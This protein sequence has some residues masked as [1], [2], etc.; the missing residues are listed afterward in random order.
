MIAL[1]ISF[2]RMFELSVAAALVGGIVLLFR[3]LAKRWVSPGCMVVLWLIVLVKLVTPLTLPGL[4]GVE[5]WSDRLVYQQPY[6]VGWMMDTAAGLWEKLPWRESPSAAVPLAGYEGGREAQ[7]DDFAFD[8]ESMA[9]RSKAGAV[10][11]LQLS[12][13]FLWLLGCLVWAGKEGMAAWRTRSLIQRGLPCG[14]NAVLELL[15]Q[16]KTETGISAPVQLLS[17]GTVFPFLYGVLRPRIMLPYDYSEHYTEAELRLILLH[18]LQHWRSRD[19]LLQ[20]TADLLRIPHWFNPLVHLAAVRLRDDLELRCDKRVLSRL[21][22][23]DKLAYGRLLLKQGELNLRLSR[24]RRMGAAVHWLE[25][26]S[27]LTERV[28]AVSFSLCATPKAKRLRLAAGVLAVIIGAGVLPGGSELSRYLASTSQVPTMY[29]FWLDDS[30]NPRSQAS[31]Q[32][33][34]ALMLG[35][36][37]PDDGIELLL[38][39]PFRGSRTERWLISAHLMLLD[40]DAPVRVNT[41]PIREEMQ[42]RDIG[43]GRI[44]VLLHF[45]FYM[46]RSAGISVGKQSLTDLSTLQQLEQIKLY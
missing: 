41:R 44:L 21:K 14:D 29:A 7:W 42:R 4:T 27:A 24:P 8:E 2:A 45:P 39:Q 26:Q 6:G 33:I 15:E 32:Q 17:G 20:L 43:H 9:T 38:N 25:S 3:G 30:V 35:E 18:E 1:Q 11:G 16:C 34:V 31:L 28:R 23:A 40:E 36:E 37:G 22:H 46:G 13:A 19:S 10:N 12:V 5:N